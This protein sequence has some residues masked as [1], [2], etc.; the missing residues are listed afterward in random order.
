M[1][2]LISL[3]LMGLEPLNWKGNLLIWMKPNAESNAA[4][5]LGNLGI[6]EEFHFNS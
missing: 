3:R 6:K 4:S 5:L 2:K 1:P